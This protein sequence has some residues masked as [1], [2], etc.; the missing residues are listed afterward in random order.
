MS[1][2][3][4]NNTSQFIDDVINDDSHSKEFK[5]SRDRFAESVCNAIV[6]GF[7]ML[8]FLL[9]FSSILEAWFR[10]INID[11]Y[12]YIQRNSNISKEVHSMIEQ[13][14]S[15]NYISRWEYSKIDKAIGRAEI[16]NLKEGIK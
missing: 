7:F 3:M 10:E 16:D 15:D 11:D 2:L 12:K 8:I 14:M 13:S 6:I 1:L 5:E 9:M 4:M